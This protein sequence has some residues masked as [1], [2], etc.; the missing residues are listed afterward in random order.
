MWAGNS[1]RVSTPLHA[2]SA[3]KFD[4]IKSTVPDFYRRVT[5]VFPEML[6]HERYYKEMD[7]AAV[8][9]RYGQTYEGVRLWIDENITEEKHPRGRGEEVRRG[10]DPRHQGAGGLP[11]AVPAHHVH[12]GCVQA[13]DPAA[14][15][16][17]T[18]KR[19][20]MNDPIGNIE[21]RDAATLNGNDYNPNCV[22]GRSCGCSSDRSC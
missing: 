1:L 8:R 7:R 22:F 9:E 2:E 21:W 16:V 12:V 18:E 6:A 11:A 4:L 14:G 5:A 20:R 15:H 10:D 3:K 13:G 19:G 17:A